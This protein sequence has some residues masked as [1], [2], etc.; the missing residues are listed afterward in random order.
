[1]VNR[2]FEK[3]DNAEKAS[4]GNG[5]VTFEA[6]QAELVTPAWFG[7]GSPESTLY[8]LLNSDLFAGPDGNVDGQIN[9]D[10]L[11]IFGLL[12][13][14]GDAADKAKHFYCLLQG[15]LDKNEYISAGDKDLAPVFTQICAFS[16]WG[17]FEVTAEHGFIPDNYSD[18][19]DALKEQ[20]ETVQ[21]D[22]FVE[23]V[24]GISSKLE[25]QL[26]IDTVSEKVYWVLDAVEIRKRLMEAAGIEAKHFNQAAVGE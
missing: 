14:K 13:C 15:G 8:R 21:E 5:F 1:M 17:L 9:A 23:D 16:T 11:R 18:Q 10:W 7:L 4:G 24:F 26:W 25:N 22:Q 20:V 6:L 12:H 3:V 19:T 2:F